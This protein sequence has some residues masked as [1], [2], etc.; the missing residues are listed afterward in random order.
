M[1]GQSCRRARSGPGCHGWEKDSQRTGEPERG[2]PRAWRASQPSVSEPGRS[3]PGRPCRAQPEVLSGSVSGTTPQSA[4]NCA[5]RISGWR[6][7]WPG[8]SS[9]GSGQ[10]SA[11]G[12]FPPCG[13]HGRQISATKVAICRPTVAKTERS[14]P[15]SRKNLYQANTAVGSA[16][17][18]PEPWPAT[19][20][21]PTLDATRK[22]RNARS[23]WNKTPP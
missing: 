19:P 20:D 11:Q 8:P 17:G 3:D 23:L 12:Q 18:H 22:A 21:S 7:L 16:A 10:K 9:P 5:R 6:R 13:Y 14:K 1:S 2:R 4:A 15:Y